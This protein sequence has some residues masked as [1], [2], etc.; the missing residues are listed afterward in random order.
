MTLDLVTD[1]L[2]VPH[3][4]L[5]L[6]FEHLQVSKSEFIIWN[7][8]FWV[9]CMHSIEVGL[10]A[11]IGASIAFYV[12]RSMFAPIRALGERAAADSYVSSLLDSKR[13]IMVYR[14]IVSIGIISEGFRS[15]PEVNFI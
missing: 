6:S 15:E 9:A 5:L 12:L 11:S 10:G 14:L 7:V 8:A 1:A 3:K 4:G 13:L 2:T